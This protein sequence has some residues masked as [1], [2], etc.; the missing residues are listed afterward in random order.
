MKVNIESGS[1]VQGGSTIT[2]QVAKSFLADQERTLERKVR[3]AMLSVRMES[4][5]GKPTIL[6]IYLN[7]IFLGHGAYGVG[8]AASRYFDKRLDELSLAESALIAGLAQAPSRWSPVRNPELAKRRR[9]EVLGDMVE[10]GYLEAPQAERAQAEPIVLTELRD[11]FRWRAPYFAEHARRLVSKELGNEAV[12]SEGLVIETSVNLALQDRA[13]QVLDRSVRKLDRRHGWRGP[14]AKLTRP[15]TQ[16]KLRARMIAEYGEDPLSSTHPWLLG[17]VTAV[18][19]RRARVSLGAIEGVLELRRA[20]WAAPYRRDTGVNSQSINTL[21]DTLE[22]GDVIWVHSWRDQEGA[23]RRDEEG[24]PLL[25]LGQQP[26]VEGTLLSYDHR[27]AYVEAM[28]GGVDYD[29]SQF[30]RATQACRSPGSVF[31]AIYYTLALDLGWQMDAVLEA[32]PWEPEP[33]EEWNPRNIDKTLDGR[34]LMRTALIKSLNTP[35]I[36]LFL[37]LGVDPVI[38]F[39]RH[40][41]FSSELIPDK[42]LSLGASC[43]HIDELSAA[44]SVFAR[45]GTR[46]APVYLRRVVDKHGTVR[47]D[48]RHPHDGGL[49]VAGRI[50]RMAALASEPPEQLLDARTNFLISRLLR[51]VVTRGT[52]TRANTIGVPAAGKSG[53]ASGR[54]ERGSRRVDLTTDAWFV[55][56]T[57]AHLTTAW[58]GFDDRNERSLGDEEASYTTAIP[59]WTEYMKTVVEGREHEPIP[60]PTPPGVGKLV[61]DATH[62]GEPVE[63]MPAATIYYRLDQ[64]DATSAPTSLPKTIP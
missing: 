46:Q 7:K 28:A 39:A 35:S 43:V 26:Q 37:A 34:V 31:K 36:R 27:S 14:E 54:Y 17:L 11:P 42:G 53:T 22:V 61:V 25:E 59:M 38:E 32:K 24:A 60:G 64:R 30:N 21:E 9:D 23:P 6:E 57:S 4:R 3:E 48:R 45:G 15:E 20:S 63:G 56:F 16:A 1:I 13:R 44:F 41:G 58:V 55:G 8:A 29:R 10:A 49:D 33:G 12:L 52:S 18:E 51:E 2:Q 5:L 62:G 50:D 19:D 47:I 40:L